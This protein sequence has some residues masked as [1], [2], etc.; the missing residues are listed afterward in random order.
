MYIGV[1]ISGGVDS[2]G[3]ILRLKALGH[4][5]IGLHGLFLDQDDDQIEQLVRRMHLTFDALKIPL[6]ILDLRQEFQQLVVKQALKAW[7]MGETPNPC[8][9][10]NRLIKFGRLLQHAKD[11]GCD[12][13]A[14]G[15]YANIACEDEQFFF[16]PP[17]DK[18]KDQTY[19]L[20]LV[21][22]SAL[23]Q[24]AFPLNGL[25]KPQC[26]QLVQEARCSIPTPT[27]SQDVCFL[28]KSE[29]RAAYFEENWAKM[30][31]SQPQEGKIFLYDGQMEEI[32]THK[33]LWRYTE[34][35]RRGLNIPYKE[36]LYVLKKN[37]ADNTLIV[38]PRHYLGMLSCS[39]SNPNIFRWTP[40]EQL[41]VKLRYRNQPST[42][43]VTIKNDRLICQF[44]EPVFPTAIGQI[45]SVSDSQGKIRAGGI[46]DSLTMAY[47]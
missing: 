42:C 34:G 14:T 40:N 9:N 11:L 18:V 23:A 19:F 5:V 15:H 35:Q 13:L 22:N 21:E 31:L 12:L 8:A 28:P 26:R 43:H 32:G 7:Q 29:D 3:A 20:S 1:A 2:L 25:T 47:V 36:G 33:G 45:A 38:G 39:C 41:F 27:E 16:A 37:L 44:S 24:I 30:G 17:S 4:K 10:C 6:K 46:V